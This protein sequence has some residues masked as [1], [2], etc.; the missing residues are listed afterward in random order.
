MQDEM[1]ILKEVGGI[2]AAHGSIGLSE[3]LGQRISLE[4]PSIEMVTCDRI[5]ERLAVDRLGIA[6]FSKVIVG[7]QG[8]IV[9]LLD[10]KNIFKLIDLSYK[11]TREEKKTGVITEMG[12]SFIKEVGNIVTGSYINSLSLLLKRMI[13]QPLPTLMSGSMRDILTI[14]FSPH[15]SSELGCVIESVFEEPHEQIRGS[16]YLLLDPRA[17]ADI[18]AVCKKMIDNIGQE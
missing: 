5:A 1:D 2:A 9:F 3:V 4:V 6:I 11:V 13:L 16:F 14:V 12:L 15:G 7:L 10:E 17:M 18:R 8:D